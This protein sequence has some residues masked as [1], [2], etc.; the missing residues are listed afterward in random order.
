LPNGKRRNIE[1]T[2]TLLPFT[3]GQAIC[4]GGGQNEINLKHPPL[5]DKEDVNTEE[6]SNKEEDSV[7]AVSTPTQA[8]STPEIPQALKEPLKAVKPIKEAKGY[9]PQKSE[10][11]AYA[12]RFF[13]G[14]TADALQ[15]FESSWDPKWD[16]ALSTV[17]QDALSDHLF[18]IQLKGRA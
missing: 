18:S 8:M 14:Q 3:P 16:H 13:K 12:E 1:N 2:Y 6:A 9:R 4:P 17:W 15:W 7:V 5:R 10:V 11:A